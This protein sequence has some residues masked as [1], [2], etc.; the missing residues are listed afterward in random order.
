M[1]FRLFLITGCVLGVGALAACSSPQEMEQKITQKSKSVAVAQAKSN[2]ASDLKVETDRMTFG[3]SYP[4]EAGSIAP[5]AASLDADGK[6]IQAELEKT[7]AAEQAEAAKSGFEFRPHSYEMA[8][9]VVTDTPQFLSLSGEFST[10]T[11]GAHGMYG[12]RSLVWDKRAGRALDGAALFASPAALDE[13]FGTKLCDAL[14]AERVKR[15]GG[16]LEDGGVEEFSRCI[17]TAEA[18]VLVGS[19]TGTAFDRIGIWFG[20]YVAGSYAE[21]AY[22]LD[23]PVDAAVMRAVKPVYRSAFAPAT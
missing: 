19:S 16:P 17:T 11:G 8:W 13:A 7:T 15:R 1:A 14:N 22:E 21:G 18:T 4:R 6:A 23:F 10:Y 3:Y 12:V 20:P 2:G 9:K 5:L